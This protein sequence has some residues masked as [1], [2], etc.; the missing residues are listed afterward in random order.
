MKFNQYILGFKRRKVFRVFITYLVIAWLIA[1]VSSIVLPTFNVSDNIMKIL[2]FL[3]I[4]G[5]PICLVLTWLYDKS[6][7][8][9]ENYNDVITEN[10]N[11][12]QTKHQL[13]H[14]KLIVLPFQNRS[15]D[16]DSNYFSDGLT[17]EIII[18]LSRIK[19]LDI[20]SRSTSMMYRDSKLDIISLGHELKARYI[21]QGA[22]L[23]HN[24]DLR[25]STELID[26][27][28]DLELWAEIFNG[29]IEDVFKIQEK[30][31][32]KL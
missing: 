6:K 11:I 28:K 32:K 26:I 14:K 19:E 13:D 18:R 10:V 5:C 21:L 20:V 7:K 12:E 16:K 8:G 22:V 4:L 27:E 15:P 24:G 23:K 31:S 29:K 30:V 3:L 2:I 9:I 25:I 17:E 1:Q